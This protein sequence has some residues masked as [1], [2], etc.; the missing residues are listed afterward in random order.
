MSVYMHM[1]EGNGGK[2]LGLTPSSQGTHHNLNPRQMGWQKKCTCKSKLF[3]LYLS[4]HKFFVRKRSHMHID[5][6]YF[7]N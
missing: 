7:T 4:G 2:G 3:G 5:Y 1:R 6:G